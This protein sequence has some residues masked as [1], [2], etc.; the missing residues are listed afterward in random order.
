MAESKTEEAQKTSIEKVEE[1]D[2]LDQ[3]DVPETLLL[4]VVSG[5][6]ARDRMD[7]TVLAPWLRFLWDSYRNCLELLR[8]NAQVTFF[9]HSSNKR[10]I[11]GRDSLSQD[12]SSNF[13]ILRQVPT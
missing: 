13:P 2:D 12:C 9:N 7:R 3:G 4:S 6:A 11:S 5:A 10:R 8:N 1:I